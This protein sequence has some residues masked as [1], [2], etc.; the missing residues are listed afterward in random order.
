VKAIHVP[1]QEA[2][3]KYALQLYSDGNMPNWV[4]TCFNEASYNNWAIY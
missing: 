2:P 1:F 3:V 4:D